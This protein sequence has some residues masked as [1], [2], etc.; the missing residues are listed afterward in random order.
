MSSRRT[1]DAEILA[2]GTVDELGADLL[3]ALDVTAGEGDADLVD[4]GTLEV[5]LVALVVCAMLDGIR[6]SDDMVG[7]H[8]RHYG[9]RSLVFWRMECG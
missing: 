2:L 3:E 8:T 5:A 7:A 6:Q 9:C 1:L 4:L